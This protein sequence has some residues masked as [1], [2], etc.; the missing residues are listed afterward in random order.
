MFDC[1]R[2]FGAVATWALVGSAIS[3]PIHAVE[4]LEFSAYGAVDLISIPQGGTSR[5]GYELDKLSLTMDN[6]FE[7]LFSW[8]GGTGSFTLMSTSGGT[9]NEDADVLEGIDN[10]EV[11]SRQTRLFSAW[12]QQDFGAAALAVGLMDLNA[13]FYANPASG[14]LIAP[15]YGI[16][17]EMA[18]TGPGGPSIFPQSGLAARLEIHPGKQSYVR[19]AAFNAEVGDPG[20]EGG[21]DTSFESGMLLVAEGGWTAA[22][23][24]AAGAWR[25]SHRQDDL[26]DTDIS[27]RPVQRRSQGFYLLGEHALIDGGERGRTLTGFLRAGI[28]DGDT[29]PLKSSWQTGVLVEHLFAA[30][31]DSQ[32]SLAF[33]RAQLGDKYRASAL[34]G[35]AS[36]SANETHFELTFSDKV[37]DHFTYQPDVQYVLDP[38][39]DTARKSVLVVMLRLTASY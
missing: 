3:A 38:G 36:L 17:T 20:D 18:A 2:R 11:P 29:G 16:G 9:P 4:G 35:G 15:Q 22:G 30:R 27:G 24:I 31:P 34:T 10:N 21:V 25:Y 39:G 32:L 12:L 37:F 7:K 33:N 26:F 5:R 14:L 28:S 1:F 8:R 23:K 6:D 19:V 13:E